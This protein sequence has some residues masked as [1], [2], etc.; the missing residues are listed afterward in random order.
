MNPRALTS[1]R[2]VYPK[3]KL[4]AD[5]AS[6]NVQT[7][8]DSTVADADVSG[9]TDDE[10]VE[11]YGADDRKGVQDK[12]DAEQAKRTDAADA[13]DAD[14]D[15]GPPQ[16]LDTPDPATMHTDAENEMADEP[17]TVTAPDTTDGLFDLVGSDGRRILARTD[18]N[19]ALAEGRRISTLTGEN[20]KVVPSDT[21]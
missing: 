6:P 21:E 3:E 9:L 12:I 14:Q 20:L 13:G 5:E 16:V 11:L 1:G 10:L 17:G 18:A 7:V 19:T 2:F 8:L 15:D 4:M